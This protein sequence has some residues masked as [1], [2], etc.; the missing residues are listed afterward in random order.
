[1]P[2]IRPEITQGILRRSEVIAA[3]ALG[4]FGLWLVWLGGLVL[5]PVGILF[6]AGAVVWAQMALR[7]LRFAQEVHAPG[8]VE[9]DEGQIGYLGPTFG[10]YVAIPDLTELRLV[11]VY[12]RRMWR[13]KQADGQAVLVPID[14]AG[15]ER[16]FDTFTSLPGMDM[17]RLMRA[18]DTPAGTDHA[19]LPAVA[20]AAVPDSDV[21]LIWRRPTAIA[22]TG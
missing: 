12:G 18:I 14:A 22:Q 15:A 6:I 9:V 7:R 4:A 8:V 11:T 16:L 2:L 1:M 5:T 19:G 17:A 13:L 20:P 21:Y 3:T 10:G